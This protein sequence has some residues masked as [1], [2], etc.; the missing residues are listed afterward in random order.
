MHPANDKGRE[1]GR[2]PGD[3]PQK[4]KIRE[5]KPVRYGKALVRNTITV[6]WKT[7]DWEKL[8]KSKEKAICRREE[9]YY[10][11]KNI[12]NTK[13]NTFCRKGRITETTIAQQIFYLSHNH[14][15]DGTYNGCKRHTLLH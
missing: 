5:I 9:T 1:V 10:G 12:Y 15:L 6:S 11:G 13:E 3:E 14:S 2:G 4:E 7:T 8:Y